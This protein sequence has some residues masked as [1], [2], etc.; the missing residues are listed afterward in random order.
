[1]F[2]SLLI[3]QIPILTNYILVALL[4]EMFFIVFLQ[5]ISGSWEYLKRKPVMLNGLM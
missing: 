3:V 4:M 5:W 2:Y 1:M